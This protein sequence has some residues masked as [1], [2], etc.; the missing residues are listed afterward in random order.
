MEIPEEEMRRRE[1][2]LAALKANRFKQQELRAWRPVPSYGSTMI[3]FIV[4]GALFMLL[5]IILYL[6]SDKVQTAVIEY[7]ESCLNIPKTQNCTLNFTIPATMTA[8]IY[9]YYEL[10][11]YYQNHRRYVMSRS[12]P[13]LMGKEIDLTQAEQCSPIIYNSDL[14]FVNGTAVSYV[15][16]SA[17]DPNAIAYPCGLIAKSLFNDSYALYYTENVNVTNNTP[18]TRIEFDETNIAWKSD[19]AKFK[20]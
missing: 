17:L 6:E 13:Q 20:N 5:G 12:M 15:N 7:G 4:F 2:K 10:T 8:P 19:R 14:D 16:G 18:P 3:I 9:V 11:K 1:E